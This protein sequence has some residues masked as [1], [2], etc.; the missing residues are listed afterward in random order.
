MIFYCQCTGNL[1]VSN[2]CYATEQNRSYKT[3]SQLMH[4]MNH[5]QQYSHLTHSLNCN[6]IIQ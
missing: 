1:Q 5:V 3:T 2:K 4:S 6:G